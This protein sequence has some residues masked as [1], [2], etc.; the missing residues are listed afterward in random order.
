VVTNTGGHSWKQER[1]SHKQERYSYL[2][3]NEGKCVKLSSMD[4]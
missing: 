3:E 2:E 1:H 4:H